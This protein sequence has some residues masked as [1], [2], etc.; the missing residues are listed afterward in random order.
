MTSLAYIPT[1]GQP[2]SR[3]ETARHERQELTESILAN[4][5][6]CRSVSERRR[7]QQEAVV[8]NLGLAD[9]IAAR[10]AGRGIDWDDLVQVG[11]VG[12]LKAVR[13]YRTGRGASFTA[14][15]TPTIAGEIKRYFRDYGWMVRPPRHLQELHTELG[16]VEPDLQQ[17]LHR[18]P[19]AGELAGA[20]GV[21]PTELSDAL[22][23]RGGYH[24]LSLDAPTRT[25]SGL[26]LGDGLPDDTNPF[27]V[28]ERAEWLRPALARLTDRERRIVRLRFVEG[29]TQE[30]MGAHLGVSQMQV[31]RLLAGI[32]SRLRDDL[33]ISGSENTAA[34]A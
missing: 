5:A 21:K 22:V 10:Y 32:L 30:Q 24:T 33:G 13:G 1:S 19:S 29:L 8:L 4:L 14:Y 6:G 31:S 9:G 12:L 28:V 15:A 7:L 2:D 11:R 20:L 18:S 25:D 34:T 16:S 3:A 27:E 26:T 17:R 23:A